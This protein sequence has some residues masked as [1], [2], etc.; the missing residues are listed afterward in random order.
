[1]KSS[2]NKIRRYFDE[3]SSDYDNHSLFYRENE[4]KNRLFQSLDI[5]T[6]DKILDAGTGTGNSAV[7]LT[8]FSAY[9]FGV[10]ISTNMLLA[11]KAKEVACAQADL[12]K[13]PFE[14]NI[15]DLTFC[16]QL[17]YYFDSEFLISVLQELRRVTRPN[18][19]LFVAQTT[20]LNY[21]SKKFLHDFMG[22]EGVPLFYR[23]PG[24]IRKIIDKSGFTIT[25]ENEFVFEIME[26]LDEFSYLRRL[27]L[28]EARERLI[29]AEKLSSPDFKLQFSGQ[30]I[31]YFRKYLVLRAEN[32]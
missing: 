29:E 31:S 3:F 17:F 5:R 23:L 30:E 32:S 10:D 1:M 12:R 27:S 6:T 14:N 11:A 4:L 24:E 9:V 19:K 26:N 21:S 28:K 7:F 2:L 16:R 18:G 15:F 22:I 25:L 13:L 20:P 8:K